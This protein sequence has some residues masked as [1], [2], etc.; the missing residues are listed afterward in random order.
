MT[1]REHRHPLR[2]WD[3][4][5]AALL[6]L[7][8]VLTL[9]QFFATD[10]EAFSHLGPTDASSTDASPAGMGLTLALL[11]L[12]IF[13]AVY[14]IWGRRTLRRSMRDE[15]PTLLS[16]VFLALMVLALS[17]AVFV[18]PYSAVLQALAYPA[19]WS[20]ME[21]SRDA[22]LWSTA[23]AAAVGLSMYCGLTALGTAPHAALMSAGLSAALSLAFAIAMGMWITHISV[24][25]ERY[26]ELAERLRH[27]QAEVGAL[28]A[29]AGAAAERE[30]L[31]RELHDTLTQ[32]L[33]GLVML[34]EQ[35]ERAV[36]QSDPQRAADRLQRVT[37]AAREAVSEA[38][39]L[40]ATTQPLSDSGLSW[41][42]QR[43]AARLE[44]DTG[45]RVHCQLDTVHLDRGQEVVMLRAAQEGLANA[46]RHAHAATV[47]V[48]LRTLPDHS[49]LLRIDDD[50]VGP[51]AT[52]SAR[53]STADA[54]ATASASA[55][56]GFG[57]SGL[58]DRVRL[59]GG[60]VRF[61]PRPGGGARLEVRLPASHAPREQTK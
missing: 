7:L 17:C 46:R 4:I 40:V 61:T 28:S 45:L 43:V 32:T 56:T 53:P 34:T 30:H 22:V 6:A 52:P 24:Q 20:V 9:A 57:L 23:V 27:S 58:G 19:A 36:Q 15:P 60:E 1:R 51:H 5:A 26:R 25:G 55:T 47:W 33:T 38:R 14:M 29:A 42:L 39:A 18:E 12:L 48:T 13:G 2:W 8:T 35:A 37:A 21:R 10:G 31:S 16:H 59:V 50:G 11:P 3:L 44:A 54:T 49:T 41:S